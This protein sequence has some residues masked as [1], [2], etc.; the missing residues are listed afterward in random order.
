MKNIIFLEKMSTSLYKRYQTVE[1]NIRAASNSFFESVLALMEAYLKFLLDRENIFYD[2]NY[3]TFL[4]LLKN[5]NV[6]KFLDKFVSEK[7][8]NSSIEVAKVINGH[9]HNNELI[10]NSQIVVDYMNIFY[11]F[12]YPYYVEKFNASDPNEFDKDYFIELYDSSNKELEK[13]KKQ[14]EELEKSLLRGNS[15]K[16]TDENFEKVL[17]IS[18]MN[19]DNMDRAQAAESLLYAVSTLQN[20]KQSMIED[21]IDAVISELKIQKEQLDSINYTN[22]YNVSKKL[23][24]YEEWL[25]L[26][27]KFKS[28]NI[29]ICFLERVK[30]IPYHYFEFFYDNGYD[31]SECYINKRIYL[32]I[33]SDSIIMR[34]NTEET[35]FF[36][37]YYENDKEYKKRVETRFSKVLKRIN[38]SAK[39]VEYNDFVW[40]IFVMDNI[41]VVENGEETRFD[42]DYI[43][44]N[45]PII[46]KKFDEYIKNDN[47]YKT[48]KVEYKDVALK[49]I[50]DICEY[51]SNWLNRIA[52]L[53]KPADQFNDFLKLIY[54]TNIFSVE[55]WIFLL[56]ILG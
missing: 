37:G 11:M 22:L 13:I 45:L 9:K 14:K 18:K 43:K 38:N 17:E 29:E 28:E 30:K 52:S 26:Y 25:E 35:E 32:I 3:D 41:K 49:I 7:V 33:E 54:I 39:I 56:D 23:L 21:K 51:K 36:K 34:T 42:L 1:G 16:L 53:D 55:E 50:K 8:V 40:D 31:R 5:D 48:K 12:S 44:T 10:I 46:F 15:G 6:K 27:K 24:K 2:E 47:D 19:I 4:A 20:I